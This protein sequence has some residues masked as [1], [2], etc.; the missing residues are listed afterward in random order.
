MASLDLVAGLINLLGQQGL[1]IFAS[2]IRLDGALT[3]LVYVKRSAFWDSVPV[4]LSALFRSA[5]QYV[6]RHLGTTLKRVRWIVAGTAPTR[7]GERLASIFVNLRGALQLPML[8]L[9]SSSRG[10]QTEHEA[11]QLHPGSEVACSRVDAARHSADRQAEVIFFLFLLASLHA[12]I[13]LGT[14]QKLTSGCSLHV[15]HFAR[16]YNVLCM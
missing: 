2:I 15:R 13:R 3:N 9:S 16:Q 6:A 4:S 1:S 8:R 5:Q 12:H 7:K 10:G 11:L 14:H